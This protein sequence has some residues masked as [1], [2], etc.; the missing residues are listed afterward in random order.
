MASLTSAQLKILA[1]MVGSGTRSFAFEVLLGSPPHGRLM[2]EGGASLQCEPSDV[3]ELE[4][5]ELLRPAGG[6]YE[7]TNLGADVY[8]E[9]STP[10]E[11]KRRPGFLAK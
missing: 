4:A 7:L 6:G 10:G 2:A 11:P 8:R 3:R 9:L 5:L 1:W